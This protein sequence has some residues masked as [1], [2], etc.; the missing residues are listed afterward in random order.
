MVKSKL[1]ATL[2]IM[3]RFLIT[4]KNQC[5]NIYTV[6][7][8]LTSCQLNPY[9]VSLSFYTKRSRYLKLLK[10]MPSLQIVFFICYATFTY[11]C[12]ICIL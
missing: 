8:N 9:Q 6:R 10:I 3:L 12:Y 11:L 4:F 2:K 1:N 7:C 5:H